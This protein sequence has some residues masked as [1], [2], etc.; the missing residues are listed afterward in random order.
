MLRVIYLVFTAGHRAAHGSVLVRGDLCDQAIRLAR[1][2]TA[3][4]PDE[5]E[6]T[7]LLSLLLL[8]DARRGAR[9]DEAGDLVLLADQ[10]RSKW[11]YAKIREGE[12]LLHRALLA[13]RPG[14][15][16]L[17]AAIAAC[18]SSGEIT[19]WREVAALYGQLVRYEPTAVVQANRAAAVA[20]ADGPAA[21]LAIL[22]SADLSTRL[23]NWP[24]L[25][26]ARGELL[27]QLG[28]DA[29]SMAA[30]RTALRLDPPGP[31]QTFIRRQ[32]ES[33][34]GSP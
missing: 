17:H 2:L 30:Y 32:I 21:G 33:L 12:E 13:G 11:D 28:R 25:H 1:G 24:Q 22:D 8:T 26:I 34:G 15:Y 7:G 14:A 31:E 3:L 19:D 27:R 5:P 18:H 10:D 23:A 20:M 16:Q 29:D 4:L 9:V 6:V